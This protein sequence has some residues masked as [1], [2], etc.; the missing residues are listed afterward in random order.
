MRF[1]DAWVMMPWLGEGRP[2]P[3]APGRS[4]VPEHGQM[5]PPT[6]GPDGPGLYHHR[7][8]SRD[9][10][11]RYREGPSLCV[12]CTCSIRRNRRRGVFVSIWP[13]L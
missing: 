12:P 8:D 9:G 10:C 5:V 7:R 11:L 2:G 13:W 4:L 6:V 1:A 3:A